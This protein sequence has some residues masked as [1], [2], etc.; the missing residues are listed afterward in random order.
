MVENHLGGRVV[1][2]FEAL[3]ADLGFVGFLNR[4]IEEQA[5]WKLQKAGK[6]EEVEWVMYTLAEGVRQVAV[7]LYPFMPAV[8]VKIAAPVGLDAELGPGRRWPGADCTPVAWCRRRR[9]S[10]RASWR[11]ESAGSNTRSRFHAGACF[12]SGNGRGRRAGERID[13]HR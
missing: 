10:S 11:K 7:L 6:T 1:N 9:R 4:Y 3:K 12:R 5:P 8:A 2:Y 13:H